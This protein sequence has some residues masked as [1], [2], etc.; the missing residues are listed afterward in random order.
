MTC[1]ELSVKHILD[2]GYVSKSTIEQ[3][4]PPDPYKVDRTYFW[5]IWLAVENDRAEQYLQQV[6]SERHKEV[7]KALPEKKYITPL[8]EF[9]DQLIAFEV[10]PCKYYS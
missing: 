4:F 6:V 10:K 3:Y 1:Q 5:R 7:K 9:L 8:T 2:H